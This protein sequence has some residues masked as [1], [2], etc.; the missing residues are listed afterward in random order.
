VLTLIFCLLL[1]PFLTV[2]I[3]LG[4]W[5]WLNK[6]NTKALA[7]KELLLNIWN[8]ASKLFKDLKGLITLVSEVAQPLL[9]PRAIDV[10]SEDVKDESQTKFKKA[11]GTE[12]DRTNKVEV[13]K[14]LR[15]SVKEHEVNNEEERLGATDESMNWE[16]ADGP[17]EDVMD[18]IDVFT[19]LIQKEENI[20]RLEAVMQEWKAKGNDRLAQ[21]CAVAI[22]ELKVKQNSKQELL[23]LW[24]EEEL[25]MEED[26]A[27]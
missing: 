13:M 15:Q 21:A 10:E 5:Y 19:E 25:L 16:S 27:S 8:D 7:I 9:S 20:I 23:N 14:V 11:Q 18:E 3:T 2:V 24:T 1:I 22:E 6:E 17:L 4:V 26:I 12:I